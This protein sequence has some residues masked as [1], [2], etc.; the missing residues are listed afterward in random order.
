MYDP[1]KVS[2]LISFIQSQDG[3]QDKSQLQESVKN[4]FHLR[5]DGSVLRNDFYAI[6]FSK[7]A[8]LNG[9]SNT[10]IGL[11]KIKKL[12]HLPFIVCCVTPTKN[13]LLLAN[14]TFLKKVS[15][16]SQDL[17]ED[18]IKGSINGPDIMKIFGGLENNPSNFQ[19]LYEHHQAFSFDDHLPR[20]VEAT[21]QIKP[22]GKIFIPTASQLETLEQAV[23]RTC[24][25]MKSSAYH[26][27]KKDLDQR[28]ASVHQE[29]ATVAKNISNVNLKGQA[30]EYLI[31]KSDTHHRALLKALREG[32]PLPTLFVDHE[33]DD[34]HDRID[35]YHIK[36]DIKSKALRLSSNPKGY[37]IDKLLRF[38]AEDS[39]IYLI[40]II[41][42]DE[43]DQ[44]HT[45]LCSLFH[46]P[47]LQGTRII[48]HWSGRNSRGVAQ[49]YGSALEEVVFAQD[50]N[51]DQEAAQEFL[52]TLLSLS[53]AGL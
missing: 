52:K 21:N 8:T 14:S 40:Y 12:D 49:Y 47:M 30:I 6:R 32:T 50:I 46:Q 28:V 53:T 45:R 13:H 5:K 25:F 41:T 51:I 26:Q 42:I 11:S 39:S 17:R 19:Q 24:Q 43:K 31:T 48:R 7:A 23:E 20:L 1:G 15:H 3:K 27:L 44:I 34:Y 22:S 2:Q 37:N 18:N 36:V 10:V 4:T 33:L 9:F 35:G 29:I 16:S 38:L